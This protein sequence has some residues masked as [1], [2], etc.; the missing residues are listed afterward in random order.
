MSMNWQSRR[1]DLNPTGRLL[2]HI[3]SA[4][5]LAATLIFE[6]KASAYIGE[7]SSFLE[8]I[9]AIIIISYLEDRGPA[10]AATVLMV[11]AGLWTR[12]TLHG[13]ISGEDWARAILLL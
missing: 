7:G 4:S 2:T 13:Q 6:T 12:S 11:A 1:S 8:F 9:P 5:V 3:A 10:L